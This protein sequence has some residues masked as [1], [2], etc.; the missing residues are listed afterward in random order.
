MQ[1]SRENLG[2]WREVGKMGSFMWMGKRETV[3]FC[4]G[5]RS[6]MLMVIKLNGVR[7]VTPEEAYRRGSLGRNL[8]LTRAA[9]VLSLHSPRTQRR[10]EYPA[11]ALP[12]PSLSQGVG[13]P[14]HAGGCG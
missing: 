5:I 9:V 13:L 11:L 12:P 7:L 1:I 2:T 8:P 14:S 6:R 4:A 10:S 3:P